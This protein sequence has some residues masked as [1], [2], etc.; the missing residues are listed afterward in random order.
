MGLFSHMP[1]DKTRGNGLKLRQ[2]RFRLD[3]R[4][5]SLLKGLLGIGMGCPGKWLSHYPWRSLKDAQMQNL[6]T[7]FSGEMLVLGQ[8][9]DQVILQVSSNW[10]SVNQ[11]TEDTH[12]YV[13][14]VLNSSCECYISSGA[15][16]WNSQRNTENQIVWSRYDTA[17]HELLLNYL[18]FKLLLNLNCF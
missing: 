2:G 9:L 10:D 12:Y 18:K 1:G 6:V 11:S 8:R 5:T 17:Y 16:L 14:C 15:A 7:W 4:K 13:L 3:I